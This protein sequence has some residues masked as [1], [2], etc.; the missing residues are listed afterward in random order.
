M[1]GV[2]GLLVRGRELQTRVDL[3]LCGLNSPFFSVPLCMCGTSSGVRH[4]HS[5]IVV[6]DRSRRYI[7]ACAE[8]TGGAGGGQSRWA[9]QLRVS[10]RAI[11]V[12]PSRRRGWTHLR[13][14]GRNLP[15]RPPTAR[16]P[17]HLAVCETFSA[18]SRPPHLAAAPP[19]ATKHDLSE[20]H[21]PRARYISACAERSVKASTRRNPG[22]RV[23]PG[24]SD[25]EQRGGRPI[26]A[27]AAKHSPVPPC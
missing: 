19:C 8:E 22:T 4:E 23:R 9:V 25:M 7:S 20:G 26:S 3:R 11:T 24:T 5:E 27:C 10:G 12:C 17:A 2:A 1:T 13:V 21:R 15:E 16:E 6:D 18:L 14:C